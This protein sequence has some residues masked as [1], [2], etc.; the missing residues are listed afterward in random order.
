M[1]IPKW[2]I[3]TGVNKTFTNSVNRSF[4][5][6][7]NLGNPQNK[8]KNV[9]HITGTKGKG[10]TALYISNILRESGY[11][12]NT[13]TSPH[14]F[15]CNERVLLNGVKITDEELNKCIEEVR[16][17]CEEKDK[18][19]II[20]PSLFEAL[21]CASFLAMSKNNADFNVI[22]V[23]MGGKDDA[24]NVF[25]NNP[26][27]ACVFTPIH[28]DHT[29]FLGNKIED[30]AWNKSFLIKKN[31]KLII[32]SSQAKE[33]KI[34]IKNVAKT[35]NI[36]KE[37]I[38]SYLDDYEVFKSNGF[39]DV[40]NDTIL[41]EENGRYKKNDENFQNFINFPIYESKKLNSY[42]P[43]QNPIMEG[44]YQLINCGCAI[45][46]CMALYQKGIALKLSF[47]A[48]NKG[49]QKTINIVRMQQ[50]KEGKL[51]DMLPKNSIFYVDGAHNQLASH[52]L[53]KWIL[54]FKK[55]HKNKYKICVAIARTKG[56]DN[57]IF[58]KEFFD[59]KQNPIT[60]L[61]ICT[62]ANLESI[63]E[64]PEKIATACKELNL[65][66]AVA[67]TIIEVIERTT[68]SAKN[69]PVLLICT[70]SLYIAR[71]INYYNKNT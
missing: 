20:E 2:P 6:L 7:D 32:I 30:V 24:T 19:H 58:I 59:E 33:A 66:F 68:N 29:K 23:G 40:D 13:Y 39:D 63:P 10:S 28:L 70:G 26:P 60:D 16:I 15:E 14:I 61:I 18:N 62:R 67:H 53:A 38:F 41:K 52:A 4:F 27:V 43:F 34:V 50:I 12:V 36:D 17:I 22:E 69:K 71:D 9:I 21:T 65:N 1:L 45:T 8:L 51:Y 54:N 57:E 25:D 44:E 37:N 48:I 5:I 46:T 55:E 11:V 56:V 35:L 42:F 47:E 49:I 3:Y 64:P 31:T